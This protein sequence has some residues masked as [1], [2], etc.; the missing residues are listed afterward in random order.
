MNEEE[1]VRAI[2]DQAIDVHRIVGPGMLETVYKKCLSYR[3]QK[4]WIQS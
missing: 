2:I 3:L 1:I 4:K